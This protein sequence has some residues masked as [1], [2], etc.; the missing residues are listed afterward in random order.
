MRSIDEP[1]FDAADG[2]Q[3]GDRIADR[4]VIRGVAGSGGMGTVYRARD[5][6]EGTEVALKI[7]RYADPES[8]RRFV[9]EARILASLQ[10]PNIVCYVAHGLTNA[11]AP[12]MAMEWLEGEALDR[13]LESRPLTIAE[14]VALATRLADALGAAHRQG[15]VHRDVK[16]SNVLLVDGDPCRAMLLDFGI[17]RPKVRRSSLTRTGVAVGTLGYMAPEQVRGSKDIDGRVDVFSLGCV[18]FECLSGRPAFPGGAALAVLAKILSDEVPPL[19]EVIDNIPREIEALVHSMLAKD[20]ERR[21]ADGAAVADALSVLGDFAPD[22]PVLKA[23]HREKLG[24][25]EQRLVSIVL[26]RRGD[27]ATS[28]TLTP[29]QQE[30]LLEGVGALVRAHG[31]TL[32]IMLS[33]ALLVTLTSRAGALHQA[34]PAARCAL[35]LR[36]ALPGLRVALATGRAN[37]TGPLATGPLIDRA[38]KM[39]DEPDGTAHGVAIDDATAGLLHGRFE[40]VDVDG[41]QQLTGELRRPEVPRTLLGK[42][43]PCVGRRKEMALLMATLEECIEEPVARAALVI[44]APGLGKSRLARELTQQVPEHV[45]VLHARGD[46]VGA[47]SPLSL[48][49]QL[50]RGALNFAENACQLEAARALDAYASRHPS[51]RGSE[52]TRAYVGELA[53]VPATEPSANLRVPSHDPASMRVQLMDAFEHVL[54]TACAAYPLLLVL[55]DVHWGDGASLLFLRKG[56]EALAESPIM[57]VALARPEIDEAHPDFAVDPT[58]QRIG[59]TGLSP[60]AIKILAKSVLDDAPDELLTRIVAR[61]DGNA[62]FAEELI[63]RAAT[64]REDEL[65]DTILAIMEAQLERLDP[66]ARRV[67]RAASVFGEVVWEEGVAALLGGEL[68]RADVSRWLDTMVAAELL[69]ERSTSRFAGVRELAFRHAMW[70]DVCHAMLADEDRR[71]GHRLAGAWLE[72]VGERNASVLAEHFEASDEPEL[73]SQYFLRAAEPAFWTGRLTDAITL[74][75]RG[76]DVG[77]QGE[78]RGRLLQLRSSCKGWGGAWGMHLYRDA[79]EAVSLLPRSSADYFDALGILSMAVVF[80]LNLEDADELLDLYRSFDGELEPV[81]SVAS[82]TFM[83]VSMFIHLGERAL[84]VEA[85][86]R[87]DRAT[88]LAREIDPV[89]NGIRE[90]VRSYAA[91]FGAL[92]RSDALPAA[93]QACEL[94]ASVEHSPAVVTAAWV[95]GLA[96]F[97]ERQHDEAE[98]A[99]RESIVLGDRYGLRGMT[100]NGRYHLGMI[101]LSRGRVEEARAIFRELENDASR[102]YVLWAHLMLASIDLRTGEIEA[103]AARIR[104]LLEATVRLP[105]LRASVLA[106]QA[107]VDVSLGRLD[108]ARRHA[109]E[110]LHCFT[111]AGGYLATEKAL[112][113][114]VRLLG[115]GGP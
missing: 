38:A 47:G 86:D 74:A 79:K 89:T 112:M 46:L 103:A 67:L 44:G 83:L 60:G 77:A 21:P 28:D 58:I 11:G 45:C 92:D 9:D 16:P 37:A 35:A 15:L 61:A 12:F 109:H 96:C 56:M 4:F 34:A 78:T 29:L 51:S 48:V 7:A 24:T 3:T 25:G 90:T 97:C 88:L 82:S 20:P 73:A 66:K 76:I 95:L 6:L 27:I 80:E 91:C 19:G 114:L 54:K 111:I 26:A 17:A 41:K 68:E 85:I 107:S 64:A 49:R 42:P 10:H 23:G 55:E 32:E 110:G 62:L 105:M 113:K 101:E 108:E 69:S 8:A 104:P 106:V 93:R 100:P 22:A 70:R 81:P 53:G 43:T 39:L 50:V 57:V 1:I 2:I 72:Q 30:Q 71:L 5:D 87:L 13:R 99:F 63:R 94:L 98:R 14:T 36:D 31:A 18:L 52:W 75:S 84:A 65:P 115:P 40:L 102:S 59:L 33:D